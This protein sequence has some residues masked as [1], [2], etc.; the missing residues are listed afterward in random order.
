MPAETRSQTKEM[1]RR[2][3]FEEAQ[4]RQEEARVR[5]QND[6]QEAQRLREEKRVREQKEY[7]DYQPS[8]NYPDEAT[9]QEASSD[10]EDGERQFQSNR[11]LF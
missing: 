3:M 7:D 8:D 9:S 10:D 4:R 2:L 5:R 11:A 6:V 1:Q